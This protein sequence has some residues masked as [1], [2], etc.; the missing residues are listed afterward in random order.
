MVGE[1]ECMA[2]TNSQQGDPEP[3]DTPQRDPYQPR[4][5]A[6][7]P[8]WALAIVGAGGLAIAAGFIGYWSGSRGP[9]LAEPVAYASGAGSTGSAPATPGPDGLFPTP[10]PVSA[11][12]GVAGTSATPTALFPTGSVTTPTRPTSTATAAGI[13]PATV[14]PQTTATTPTPWRTRTT[15]PLSSKTP[16]KSTTDPAPQTSK[17]SSSKPATSDPDTPD[18]NELKVA[19]PPSGLTVTTDD[20]SFGKCPST[21]VTQ[22]DV[23][24]AYGTSASAKA[25]WKASETGAHGSA[26]LTMSGYNTFTGTIKG[27]PTKTPVILTVVVTGPEGSTTNDPFEITHRC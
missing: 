8:S 20:L 7:V 14:R 4:K 18:P 17:P 15:T 10:T 2:E 12:P 26:K 5:V 23:Q 22:V 3:G 1:D 19:G 6:G 9:D 11:G 13:N 25:N 16:T 21:F 27:V 24:V